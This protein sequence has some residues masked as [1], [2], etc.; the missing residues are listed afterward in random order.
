MFELERYI[1]KCDEKEYDLITYYTIPRYFAI[2]KLRCEKEYDLWFIPRD[3]YA[4]FKY[5]HLGKFKTLKE[6]NK[7]AYEWYVDNL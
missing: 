6:A 3:G 1:D 4:I 5:K 2:Q 7:Y